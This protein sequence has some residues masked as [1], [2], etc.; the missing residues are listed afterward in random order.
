MEEEEENV[1][2]RK[3]DPDIRPAVLKQEGF[4]CC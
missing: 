4:H 3:S 2:I 1:G